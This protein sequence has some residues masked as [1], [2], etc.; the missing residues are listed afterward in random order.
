MTQQPF[1]RPGAIDLSARSSPPPSPA[2][3]VAAGAAPAAVGVGHSAYSVDGGRGE[4]PGLLESSM[5]APVLLVFY[6]RTR[7]PESGQPGR[8]PG[9]RVGELEGRYLLGLVDIDA[10]PQIAQAMQI[11][12]I[13]LVV[14]VV[15]GRPMPL[16]QDPLPIEELRTALTQVGQQLTAQ[17]ITGRHQPRSAAP[18]RPRARRRSSIRATP[19]RRTR[20]GRATSTSPSPSTR[21]SST[22]TP[23]TS[24]PPADWRW[25]RSCSA[26]RASTSTRRVPPRPSARTTSTRRRWSPTSTCSAATSRTRS[27]GW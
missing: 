15:D 10:A 25:R 9:D 20:S 14:A 22:P 24:R 17:G 5:T 23:P 2:P 19:R 1:T 7:M 13:P 8:R 6:S 16:L 11:P 4:L 26:P 12:S 18:R 27:P 21:S 3:T